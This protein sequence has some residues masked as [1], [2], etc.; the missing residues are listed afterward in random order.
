MTPAARVAIWAG[1][2]PGSAMPRACLVRMRRWGLA[3][4]IVG[5]RGGYDDLRW[6]RGVWGCGVTPGVLG[7]GEGGGDWPMG[8]AV[9]GGDMT[10]CGGRGV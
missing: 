6:P 8:M 3:N 2:L 4:G 7:A 9:L 1:C 10:I 5:A